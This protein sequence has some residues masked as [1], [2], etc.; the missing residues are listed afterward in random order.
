MSPSRDNIAIP[1]TLPVGCDKLEANPS[2]IGSSMNEATT[3]RRTRVRQEPLQAA[4]ETSEAPNRSHRV[5]APPVVGDALRHAV[6]SLETALM[7]PT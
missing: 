4:A 1:V 5:N 7:P 6:S 2:L 3:A